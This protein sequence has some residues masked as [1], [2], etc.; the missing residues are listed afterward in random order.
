[1][2]PL[3]TIIIFV[4]V[5]TFTGGFMLQSVTREKENR[6]AEVLLVSLRLR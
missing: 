3:A 2:V 5:L 4:F 6:T 1:V